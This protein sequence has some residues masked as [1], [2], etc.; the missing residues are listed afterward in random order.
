MLH[1]EFMYRGMDAPVGEQYGFEEWVRLDTTFTRD[2]PAHLRTYRAGDVFGATG[3]WGTALRIGG[4]QVASNFSTQP[5][6]VT[7]PVPHLQGTAATPSTVDLYIDGV[8]RYRREVDS[9]RF[10]IDDVPTI[11]GAGQLTM[12][13]TDAF[14]RE[15]MLIQ[16][17]YASTQ[18]LR[19]RAC[20]STPTAS[21]CSARTFS[22]ASN[23]YDEP[24]FIGAHRVGIDERWTAGGRLE[25]SED[26]QLIG[27]T[28]DLG[29]HR[30]GVLSSGVAF[31]HSERDVGGSLLLGYEWQSDDYRF[32]AQATGSTRDMAV[33]DPYLNAVP[34]K[35]QFVANAGMNRG[36]VG[37]HRGDLRTPVVLGSRQPR[38]VHGNLQRA[39]LRVLHDA[40]F[41]LRS[42][43]HVGLHGRHDGIAQLWRAR[44]HQHD[45]L[46]S[47]KTTRAFASRPTIGRRSVRDSGTASAPRW[48][49]RTSS[50]AC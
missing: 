41:E 17:V 20:R 11:T 15:Q 45:G 23:D 26:V 47:A 10:R 12:V 4:L 48:P 35:L 19:D 5:A 1:S 28:T 49:G 37:S 31:S 16:D 38:R 18:L 34:K 32:R 8:L 9:G 7:F 30:G 43:R 24:A 6:L 2:D 25:L 42:Q 44:Q 29:L 21:G 14:G 39:N 33:V 22:Y 46:A 13:T 50:T 36:I 27:G 40:V 3:P